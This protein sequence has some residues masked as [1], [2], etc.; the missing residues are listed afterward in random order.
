MN[1]IRFT[2]IW[3]LNLKCFIPHL[4]WT[5]DLPR[6]PIL[7]PRFVFLL[8]EMN[9]SHFLSPQTICSS[10]LYS[11]ELDSFFFEKMKEI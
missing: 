8:S 11:N 3:P 4:K 5:L 2:V 10:L 7:L 9:I 1:F 6:N